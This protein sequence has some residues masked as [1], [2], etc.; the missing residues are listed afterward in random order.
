MNNYNGKWDWG[1]FI[2]H[3]LLGAILCTVPLYIFFG[4]SI[5]LVPGELSAIYLVL[6]FIL[7]FIVTG[8]FGDR[9]WKTIGSIW[10]TF[11]NY[12]WFRI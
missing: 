12:I 10:D 8:M 9:F 3:G 5:N 2:L 7:S 4:Q 6:F 1:A 11:K